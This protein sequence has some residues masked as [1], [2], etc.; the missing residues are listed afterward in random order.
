MLEEIKYRIETMDE[1]LQQAVNHLVDYKTT[2]DEVRKINDRLNEEKRDMLDL[3]SFVIEAKR[4]IA[5][6]QNTN[7]NVMANNHLLKISL[8][9]SARAL[10]AS[11]QQKVD[12][13][14]EPIAR[15]S[16]HLEKL[17]RFLKEEIPKAVTVHKHHFIEPKSKLL[18]ASAV[19][20][21]VICIISL[22]WA[23]S[24]QFKIKEMRGDQVKLRMIKLET[25]GFYA[26]VDSVYR[27]D[28]ERARKIVEE[29]ESLAEELRNAELLQIEKQMEAERA[30]EKAAEL[31]MK[32]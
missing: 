27:I 24:S 3:K 5:I 11:F 31:K 28:P 22:S 17:H 7:E 6:T 12:L 10:E 8:D 20:I 1:N 19:A 14:D 25:P 30:R 9:E 15:Y 16:N 29:R 2:T 13:L 4:Q 26:N 32:K 21:L 18:I 23:I